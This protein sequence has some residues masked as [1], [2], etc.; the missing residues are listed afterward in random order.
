MK[1]IAVPTLLWYGDTQLRLQFPSKWKINVC[2]MMGSDFPPLNDNAIKKAYS[3]PIGSKTIGELARTSKEVAIVVDDMTRPTRIYTL[4]PPLLRELE[5]NGISDSHIRFIVGL[6]LHGA[7]DRVDFVKKLGEEVVERFPIYNHNPF[8]SLT[9]V[10]DTS[11]GTPVQV[12]SEFMA[13][14]LKIGIGCIVPHP[15]AGFGGGSKIILPGIVGLDT[16]AHN[17]GKVAG[18]TGVKA[19]PHSS[20]GWGKVENN[21][22]Q[23]DNREAARLV[24]LNIKID[25]IINGWGQ[26]VGLFVGDV[27][28]EYL[29]GLKMAKKVY[30]T[31][32]PQETD[33]VIANT[34]AK[35]N[36]ASLAMWLANK[37][38]KKGGT[39]VLIANAPDGQV[40]HYLYG[41]F[42]ENVGG[43]LYSGKRHY[44][45]LGKLIV[46][47]P[48]IVKDPFLQIAD[49]NEMIWLKNWK[50]VLEE[51]E[52]EH[53]EK[54]K[55]VLYPNT[56]I[57][58][59]PEE[60]RGIP[61]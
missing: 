43:T 32:T 22:L 25:A 26:T 37:T 30:A 40:T 2:P 5:E 27:Y 51:L 53:S 14:D 21:E 31:E 4:L 61:T 20:T 13:C 34:Y 8:G 56:E 57:Q 45:K 41:K 35:A 18:Y 58:I 55:V 7:C 33:I 9:Y 24:G 39:I 15:Y 12:N 6:G 42:G 46:Y 23:L 1:E 29:A 11:R 47:S 52:K 60:I 16:I 10:G 49:P 44:P 3:K 28:Q 36:E 38:V 19:T 17:H 59:P 50:E 48:H 54:S